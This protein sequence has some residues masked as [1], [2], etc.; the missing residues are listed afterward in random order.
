MSLLPEG[1]RRLLVGGVGF[2]IEEQLRGT[3]RFTRD[4]VVTHTTAGAERPLSFTARWGHHRAKDYLAP[5]SSEFLCAELEGEITAGGLCERA[6]IVG[7]LELR[8]LKDATVRYRFEFA[9]QDRLWRYAGEKRGIR[10]WNLHRSHT[11]CYGRITEAGSGEVLSESVVYFELSQL[12][13]FLSS[14]RLR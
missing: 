10:P 1:L 11:T 9:A 4:L 3:H 13:R 2:S 8:Y 14:L 5:T 6:P 7:T 12:P